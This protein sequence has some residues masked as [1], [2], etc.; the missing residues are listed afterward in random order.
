[1]MAVEAAFAA[2]MAALAALAAVARYLR[3]KKGKSQARANASELVHSFLFASLFADPHRSGP[4]RDLHLSL[5]SL[6]LIPLLRPLPQKPP[7]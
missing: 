5:H 1:M 4:I 3:I 7:L 6:W 2:V